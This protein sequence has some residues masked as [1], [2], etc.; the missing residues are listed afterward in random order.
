[1]TRGGN[2]TARLFV[3]NLVVALVLLTLV[4][5]GGDS[6]PK[7]ETAES[8]DTEQVMA[9]ASDL[10]DSARAG[11]KLFNN[12][13]SVCHGMGAVGTTQGPPL[14]DRVYHPGHHPDFSIRNAVNKGVKQHHWVFGNMPPVAGVSSDD[15]EEI[16]CYV[17]EIQRANGLFE[18]DDFPTVC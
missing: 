1:M 5:C 7:S 6:P 3:F 9:T 8:K 15:V 2:S 4:G 17:R 10:P 12:N 16:I 13:C 18:G 11:E 14:I